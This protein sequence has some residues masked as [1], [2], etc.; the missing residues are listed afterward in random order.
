[1][2]LDAVLAL[3]AAFNTCTVEGRKRPQSLKKPDHGSEFIAAERKGKHSLGNKQM[4]QRT[5]QRLRHQD[6]IMRVADRIMLAS[7]L[8]RSSVAISLCGLPRV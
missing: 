1:M 6:W 5:R 3:L 4:H 7:S 2:R 8:S